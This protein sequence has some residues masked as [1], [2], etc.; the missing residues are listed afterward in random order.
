L[1]CA[2]DCWFCSSAS[3]RSSGACARPSSCCKPSRLARPRPPFAFR[4]LSTNRQQ[5][6]ASRSPTKPTMATATPTL[7]I[8]E[9]IARHIAALR[10]RLTLWFW[11]DG[12]GR[13]LL[14][15]IAIFAVDL[16]IDW[17]FRLDKSQRG[18]MWIVMLGAIGYIAYRRLLI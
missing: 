11:I 5:L 10:A 2:K 8:P 4:I 18:V 1:R 12:L 13:L 6:D 14:G 17:F 7:P 15:A 9:A 16:A 3:C